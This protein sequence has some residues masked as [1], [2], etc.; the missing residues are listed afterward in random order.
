MKPKILFIED[1]SDIKALY[2]VAFVKSGYE[3]IMVEDVGQ[4][5]VISREQQPVLVLLDLILPEKEGESPIFDEYLGF[6]YLQ[7]KGLDERISAIP[8]IVFSNL[9]EKKIEKK[10]RELGAIDFVVK[11]QIKPQKMVEFVKNYLK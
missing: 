3:I 11:S 9:K 8:V 6:K 4:A 7:A 1:N 10:A 2:E 5:L